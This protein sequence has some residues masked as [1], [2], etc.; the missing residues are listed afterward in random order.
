M[1]IEAGRPRDWMSDERL[2]EHLTEW[3]A[4]ERGDHDEPVLRSVTVGVGVSTG[5]RSKTFEEKVGREV[6][7]WV[8]ENINAI[9]DGDTTFAQRCALYNRYVRAV[10]RLRLDYHTELDKAREIVRRALMRIGIV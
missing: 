2:D 4:A 1:V 3:G 6:D 9:I 8:L 7:R 10:Y 5:Y